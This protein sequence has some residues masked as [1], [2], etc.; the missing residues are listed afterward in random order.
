MDNFDTSIFSENR[1]SFGHLLA[2]DEEMA[3]WGRKPSAVRLTTY[4]DAAPTIYATAQKLFSHVHIRQKWGKIGR[5]DDWMTVEAGKWYVNRSF[6]HCGKRM[7]LLDVCKMLVGKTKSIANTDVPTLLAWDPATG[8]EY[9]LV[10]CLRLDVD[11]EKSW[12]R[13]DLDAIAQQIRTE[14]TCA[15]SLGLPYRCYRTGGKG[16][17]IVIPLPV[18]TPH[19][20]AWWWLTALKTLIENNCHPDAILDKDNLTSLLRLPGGIH[21]DQAR[22]A[23]WIN[24]DTMC[25]H[26]I[27]TQ[28]QMMG[29]G[30][31]YPEEDDMTYIPPCEFHGA[32]MEMLEVMAR[33]GHDKHDVPGPNRHDLFFSVVGELPVNKV[34][35]IFLHAL[36]MT[37]TNEEADTEEA[38]TETAD[39]V[40]VVAERLHA[41]AQDVAAFSKAARS[42]GGFNSR[43]AQ[44]VVADEF[45]PGEFW[46]WLNMEGRRGI[47]ALWLVY[48]ENT[49]KEAIAM[50]ERVPCRS[51]AHRRKRIR[52][53]KSYW[54]HFEIKDGQGT[55]ARLQGASAKDLDRRRTITGDLTA[56][57]L[58]LA[59]S[60]GQAIQ[61]TRKVQTR[62][63]D[64]LFRTIHVIVLAMQQ[65]HNGHI[66]ISAQMLADSVCERW[67]ETSVT[68][69]NVDRLL[70]WLTLDD[71]EKYPNG[72]TPSKNKPSCK[73]ALL[74]LVRNQFQVKYG[75][76]IVANEFRH[77]PVL[78]GTSLGEELKAKRQ[79][80]R[81]QFVHVSD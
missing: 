46:E 24:P 34:V 43:W 77:G 19:L 28:A 40:G 47:L 74:Q 59:E 38:D 56:E 12:R 72:E 64:T 16:H 80:Y 27:A 10:T 22:L 78:A 61:D 5:H 41:K 62:N 36:D 14:R 20:L 54:H 13:R 57:S 68:R 51:E 29:D 18:P 71:D 9:N 52:T 37:A 70:A 4:R 1:L 76:W 6:K 33:H 65:S 81:R 11:M 79:E 42:D 32:G 30:F 3:I 67:P 44:R 60:L 2:R 39:D 55:R 23:M 21:Q 31:R 63:L 69:K 58:A 17:Q 8:W 75:D 45:S 25:L 53:I 48:G 7:R 35:R 15:R 50:A 49:L 26:D 73:F 66:Q